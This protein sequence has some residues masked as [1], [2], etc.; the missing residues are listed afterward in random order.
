MRHMKISSV[1]EN[2]VETGCLE[3]AFKQNSYEDEECSVRIKGYGLGLGFK[4][5]V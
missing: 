5:N 2:V 4:V 3:S 1:I